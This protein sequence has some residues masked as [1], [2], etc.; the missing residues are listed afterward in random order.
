MN[1]STVVETCSKQL[2]PFGGLL[3]L[4]K[5]FDLVKF[6]KIFNFNYREP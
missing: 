4:V 6:K 5:F 1:A 3:A 2:S